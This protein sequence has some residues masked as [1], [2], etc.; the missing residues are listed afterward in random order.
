MEIRML[1]LSKNTMSYLGLSVLA[2]A[3]MTLSAC[4]GSP[5]TG[6]QQ[7]RTDKTSA[8]ADSTVMNGA[9]ETTGMEGG[10]SGMAVP[11][12][13]PRLPPVKAY[14]EGEE[15]FFVHPEAS[16]EETAKLLTDMMGSPVLVVPELAQVPDEALAKVYV[17]T[18]GIRGDGPLGF[19]PDVFD[20]APGDENYSP[21]RRL[22]LVTWQDE[23]EAREIKTLQSV[24]EARQSGEVEIERQDTVINEPF[25]TW[26]GGQR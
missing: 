15:V 7:E 17:F 14:Y 25:L 3:I 2:A 23:G 8:G 13:V 26:P 5:E 24:I 12:N 6:Q 16:D 9:P 20:S 18:N 21:L 10:M 11:D 19:Q 4:G 22:Y 1:R